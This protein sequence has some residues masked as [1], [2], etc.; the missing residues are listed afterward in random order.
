MPDAPR[1]N[2]E[3]DA[4]IDAIALVGPKARIKERLAVWKDA[5]REG[6]VDS[7]LLSGGTSVDALR[8]VA[9]EVL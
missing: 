7:L 9:E 6:K 4:L 2:P 3:S 1:T 5:A 8:F